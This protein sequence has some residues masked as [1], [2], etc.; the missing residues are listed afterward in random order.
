MDTERQNTR[1][2]GMLPLLTPFRPLL[3]AWLFSALGW[4]AIF[5]ALGWQMVQDLSIPASDALR[6]FGRNWLVWS[7]ATPLIFRFVCRFP[8]ER[9]RWKVALPLHLIACVA[10][11]ASLGWLGEKFPPTQILPPPPPMNFRPSLIARIFLNPNFPV[12]L[13][14]LSVSH[15]LYFNRR[16]RERGI[17]AAELTASLAEARLQALR[18]QIQPHFLFNSLNALGALIQKDSNAAEQMLAVL[19]DFLRATLEGSGEPEVSIQRELVYVERYLTI[20]KVRFG[21][22]LKYSILPEEASLAAQLPTLLLQPLVENAVRHGIEP[23]C[24]DGLILIKAWLKDGFLHILVHDNGAGI[25]AS[26]EEGIG[27][28]NIRSRLREHYGDAGSL[29]IVSDHGT[30]VEIRLPF[31]LK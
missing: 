25:A 3:L 11:L 30:K 13:T 20:E 26:A 22:R 18:M 5:L 4:S 1:V 8:I 12:Y 23:Q 31:H 19:G 6:L 28:S 14:I 24:R 21:G 2:L 9:E 7:F 29:T 17:R 27:L 10:F 15:A 16:G